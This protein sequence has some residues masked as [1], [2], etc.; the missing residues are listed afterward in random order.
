MTTALKLISKLSAE[1]I[2]LW[3]DKEGQLRFKAPKGALTPKLK[4][5]LVQAKA[6]I[7]AFLAEAQH[8]KSEKRITAYPRLESKHI[9][10]SFSQQRMW[11]LDRL[12]P[13]NPS[14]HISVALDIHG[15]LH[16]E[17]LRLAF[18]Q[19]V[20]RHEI[21]RTTF[22]FKD[23]EVSQVIKAPLAWLLDENYDLSTLDE[24]QQKLRVQ[25]IAKEESLRSFD[26]TDGTDAPYRRIRLL[27]SRLARL[28][29]KTETSQHYVL[30][31]TMHHIIADGWSSS[32]LVRELSQLYTALAEERQP[33]LPSLP[34]QYADY[35][36]WQHEWMQSE[37]K[38]RQLSYWSKQLAEVPTL[39]LPT[40]Y[41]RPPVFSSQ[42]AAFRFQ[43]PEELTDKLKQLSLKTEK[44]LFMLTLAAYNLLLARYSGQTDFCVGTPIANRSRT[45][46]ESL[47]GCFINTLALRSTIEGN[48]RFCD[49]LEDVQNA[50][51]NAYANQD[52]PFELLVEEL[53]PS[54]DMAFTPICQVLFTLQSDSPIKKLQLPGVT[55]ENIDLDSHT[56]KFDLLFHLEEK[57]D[58]L[59][60]EIEYNSDLF[61]EETIQRFTQHYHTLLD[62]IVSNPEQ[63]INELNLLPASER[64]QQLGWNTQPFFAHPTQT[65]HQTFEKQAEDYANEIA[66]VCDDVQYTYQALN[67][68]SN[69]I[70]RTLQSKGVISG[71]FVGLCLERS[72]DLVAS[73]IGILKAGA[74]YVPLD[75]HFPPERLQY[76]L[77]DSQAKAL[78]TE[79]Q[80]L[81]LQ[82][83]FSGAVL[84][85]DRDDGEIGSFDQQNLNLNIAVTQTAYI[86]YTSGT[87]GKPKGCLIS[88]ANVSRLFTATDQYF[89][90]NKNDVWTLFHSFAFD[91]SVW[92]IWGALFYGGKLVV[93]PYAL[94]RSPEE[95]YQLLREQK[96]SVLNQTPSAFS[97]LIAAD[98]Q[99]QAPDL[100]LRY[101]IFGGEA[102]D[103]KALLQ[104]SERHPLDEPALINM[105]GI[106]ETT[107]HVTKHRVSET[108]LQQGASLIGRPI[109]DL[110]VHILDPQ[111]Q[112][113]PTGV[114]GEMFI[115]GPGVSE[116]YLN[117]EDLT[118]ERFIPNQFLALLPT[119]QQAHHTHLYRSGDLARYHANGNIEYL[120][121]IDHQVKIRGHRIE[122]GEIESALAQLDDVR[123]AIVLVKEAQPGDKRLVA[124]LLINTAKTLD[125]SET[126]N[127]LKGYLP[128]YMMPS[129][130]LS[131]TQW[132]LTGNGKIDKN[133]LPEPDIS[134]YLSTDHVAPRNLTE[135]HVC[136]IWQHVLQVDHIGVFD[137]FFDLGGHSLLATRL[138]SQIKEEFGID[139]PLRVFFDNPT[140][141]GIAHRLEAGTDIDS[142]VHIAP[143]EPIADRTQPLPLSF[144]QERLWILEQF[145][146]G[147]AAYNIPAALRLRGDLNTT[148]LEQALKDIV[149]RHEALRT[150]INNDENGDGIQLIDDGK[151]FALHRASLDDTSET[152]IIAA[153]TKEANT[154]FD[155]QNDMLFRATVIAL[156]EQDHLLLITMHHIISDGW[157]IDILQRE[158]IT[159]Y[160]AAIDQQTVELPPLAIQY[161][162]FAAWQRQWQD[163]NTLQ[164]HLDFW[165]NTLRGAPPILQLPYD[166]PRPPIQTLNGAMHR[167]T[168]DEQ[169]ASQAKRF[170]ADQSTTLYTTLLSA[171]ALLLSRYSHQQDI[172]IGTPV[173][174]RN[175][176]EVENLIG[177][178]VNT[179]VIR[180]DLKG[181]PTGLELLERVKEGS[182][183]AFAHQDIP[184]ERVIDALDLERNLSHPPLAQ[185]GFSFINERLA[186]LSKSFG[187]LDVDY[188]ERD[189][190]IAK[191]DLILIVVD[192]EDGIGGHVEYNTD[193][194][195]A[196][197]IDVMMVHFQHLLSLLITQSDRSIAAYEMLDKTSLFAAVNINEEDYA[198][199][200]PLT[201][202]QR[203]LY[204]NAQINPNTR[205][206]TIG[207][208]LEL[209]VPLDIELWRQANEYVAR[210]YIALR[211]DIF[212]S[213]LP[214]GEIAYQCVRKQP[215]VDIELVDL[216][217]DNLDKEAIQERI[218]P[219]VYRSCDFSAGDLTTYHVFKLSDQHYI[220]TIRCNHKI[221]DGVSLT[222]HGKKV[223]EIYDRLA[224]KQPLDHVELE[225]DRWPQYVEKNRLIM[226]TDEQLG[227]WRQR[228]Q[229]C[230]PLDYP[231]SAQVD[232]AEYIH[233]H[234]RIFPAHWQAIKKY[235]FK[236][237]ITPA[238]YFKCLYGLMLN[239]YCRAEEDFYAIEFNA[240]RNKET[241]HSQGCYFLP[242]PFVFDKDKL[243]GH[244]TIDELFEHAR[245]EQDNINSNPHL[246]PGARRQLTAAGRLAFMF[247]FYHF[248]PEAASIQGQNIT[249]TDIAPQVEN[250]LQLVVKGEA[251]SAYMDLYY[252]NDC[253]NET[254]FLER[255][256]HLSRQVISGAEHLNALSY[257]S[258]A[259]RQQQLQTWNNTASELPAVNS[260][261]SLIEAQV[262]RTPNHIAVIS[263]NTELS[264]QQLNRQANQLAHYLHQ[265][266]VGPDTR[267]GVCLPRSADFMVAVLAVVKAG[268][269]Y[270]PIDAAYPCERIAYI[271]Q[272][273]NV[274][275]LLTQQ[276]L[277]DKLPKYQ[278]RIIMLDEDNPDIIEQADSNPDNVTDSQ[279]LLY[280][281]Y[282]SGSTGRPKG[283]AVMHRGELN[284]LYWYTREFNFNEHSRCLIISATG[285][286]L[287]QKNL[288]APL[289]TGGTVILPELEHYDSQVVSDIIRRHEVN[290]VNCAPSAF[291]QIVEDNQDLNALASMRYLIFGGEPIRLERLQ[292]WTEAPSF[293][294]R[295]V[296]NYGPT[297]CTDI[298]TFHIIPDPID[299]QQ[300]VPVGKPNDNV[301]VYLL[302]DDNQLLPNGLA[303]EL[304]IAG[305]GVGRGYLNHDQLNLEKFIP[306]PFGEGQL[307]RSG[308][309]MR[310]RADGNL[311]FIGRKDFQIKL[312]GLR[313]ELGEIEYALQQ[314]ATISDVLVT[315]ANE[316]LTAYLISDEINPDKADWQRQLKQYLPSYM[317]PTHFIVL[318]SWPLTPNGK[319]DRK[320][321]PSPD[322]GERQVEYVAPSNEIEEKLAAILS[323][324]LGLDKVGTQD[325]FFEIGGHSL[326]ASRAVV[327]IRE[328]FSIDI[329]LNALFE[330]T[331]I[332]KLADYIKVTCWAA[333]SETQADSTSSN[334]PREEGML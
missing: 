220:A 168:L 113:A 322:A 121:R 300:I 215:I 195:D 172:C 292:R 132:P 10:L 145:A 320:A 183:A 328:R 66:V 268:G 37:S 255:L 265:L 24:Q 169:L 167:F 73:I 16:I 119:D 129:A 233:R 267:V 7:I 134:S 38:D 231:L 280:V 105:Y 57:S 293:N 286:D 78:L 329:P 100:A 304:C 20:A 83:E 294:A 44:T 138:V 92:E 68:R 203:D 95:F 53:E 278:G 74:A 296:N 22:L 163:D 243:G 110:H 88:H 84:C 160:Q 26:L 99:I 314:L 114:Q 236:K 330:M 287:S 144:A 182:L 271:L 96:V 153:V 107:V 86:I 39:K 64:Q 47:M 124:Y 254:G 217:D 14:Y 139:L 245:Q 241:G 187:G 176:A 302:N 101:V 49:Y 312:H 8:K 143:I 332:E 23:N 277:N 252:Q 164:K 77:H 242:I 125:I 112:P 270:V 3:L 46:V 230:E 190:I 204:L 159:L 276:A 98:Q 32:V 111:G 284:L 126:R 191:Y 247:N 275:V 258:D 197:T 5:E 208:Q 151:Q 34:I 219:I 226:D 82:P 4:D 165:V 137:S 29:D 61:N 307:Y 28:S 313:I 116:G 202:I 200:L 108:D 91:F 310:Y 269:A 272:D 209:N 188:Y 198:Q 250:T 141:D 127:Q 117:R 43:L 93:A 264:Y 80:H 97:A 224:N 150:R 205:S 192:N 76:V 122:L 58:Y 318:N 161:A 324:V 281:I 35:A 213:T 207:Y 306:N 149:F 263:D 162:D 298:A 154:P 216:S 227:F 211:T 228:L 45:E 290:I 157:S 131:L 305:Q 279:D 206:N 235:C 193:L 75:P 133:R 33:T 225:T 185:V 199:A 171:F 285:F 166:R 238:L 62:S 223:M 257:T 289:V 321:L 67:Q 115:S 42:G 333:D 104:W 136:D 234:H 317:V 311:E 326:A 152:A 9:P 2:K 1:G 212:A 21:L 40:D 248:F 273:A 240:G 308:D 60:G 102:L 72:V 155:L 229:G 109:D 142:A 81:D 232:Q 59:H 256:D 274:P 156:S 52:I 18:E 71:D 12:D 85:V 13:G 51:V 48:P 316:Q 56:S 36:Q 6:D 291:Y 89:G 173:A 158:L 123:E 218:N 19:L 323:G 283:A 15:K 147:S 299:C 261:Q 249:Y 237:R 69:Q 170:G 303:G 282:T 180:N 301:N 325:D 178:F 260:V 70:A 244:H 120:G 41:A 181:N 295:I 186:S 175:R 55:V 106:T 177:Y 50:T 334:T 184:V 17:N 27:R 90:F 65:L 25:E 196:E 189:E 297:E 140:I 79:E 251:D 201:P 221:T 288:F 266:G 54:R 11:F 210:H 94:T 253:F 214:Y 319:I 148:A 30:F 309:L 315:V 262:E 103:F 327:Q 130:F 222:Y 179:V 239:I 246:S 331:T 87:T 194:F 146:P 63:T 31:I 174:G 118:A 135:Q 128:D 259:E